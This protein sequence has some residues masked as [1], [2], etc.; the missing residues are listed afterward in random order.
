MN[1]GKKGTETKYKI[2]GIPIKK[3]EEVLTII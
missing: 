1:I 2:N 3:L